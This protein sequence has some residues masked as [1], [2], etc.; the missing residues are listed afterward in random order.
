MLES[1]VTERTVNDFGV[2]HSV[3]LDCARLAS[4]EPQRTSRL[5]PKP[6]TVVGG[7]TV[8]CTWYFTRGSSK[9]LGHQNWPIDKTHSALPEKLRRRKL[10]ERRLK[11]P[12]AQTQ[13]CLLS[14][15]HSTT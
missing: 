3:I 8:A 5:Y 4:C 6:L 2:A 11:G 12:R 1:W 15:R 13:G 14:M 10:H 7:V 9:V